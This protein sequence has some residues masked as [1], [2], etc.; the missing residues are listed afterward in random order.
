MRLRNPVSALSPKINTGLIHWVSKPNPS[1]VF[2]TLRTQLCR[3]LIDFLSNDYSRMNEPNRHTSIAEND[4]NGI[5]FHWWFLCIP[6]SEWLLSYELL[7]RVLSCGEL[8]PQLVSTHEKRTCHLLAIQKASV[9]MDS[10][11]LG[12]GRQVETRFGSCW[13][14]FVRSYPE[15]APSSHVFGSLLL[16][17]LPERMSAWTVAPLKLVHRR[18]KVHVKHHSWPSSLLCVTEL[19]DFFVFLNASANNIKRPVDQCSL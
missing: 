17:R 2:D 3:S 8:W 5:C 15:P 10:R 4:F 11:G 12:R 9:W 1:D 6:L 7:L 14:V 13:R 16:I 19:S 18:A